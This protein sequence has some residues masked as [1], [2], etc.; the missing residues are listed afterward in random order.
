MLGGIPVFVQ[1]VE[2]ENARETPDYTLPGLIEDNRF[3]TISGAAEILSG[4]HLIPTP[5]HTA[6]TNR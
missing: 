4:V 2:L 1:T 5:G 3:E 6:G